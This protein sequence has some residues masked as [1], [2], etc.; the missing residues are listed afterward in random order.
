MKKKED[1]NPILDVVCDVNDICSFIDFS[2]SAQ[3]KKTEYLPK[4]GI[5]KH[6]EENEGV[7]AMIKVIK[8]SVESW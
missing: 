3:K 7:K 6:F 2:S 1:E 5:L 4:K 8:K